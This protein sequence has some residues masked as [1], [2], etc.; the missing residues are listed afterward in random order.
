MDAFD[1]GD[2][3]T[4]TGL[5]GDRGCAIASLLAV[6]LRSFTTAEG[7]DARSAVTG[8]VAG[9][10]LARERPRCPTWDQL[11]GARQWQSAPARQAML[12]GGRC[13]FRVHDLPLQSS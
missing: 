7:R 3:E 4:T 6:T 12:N 10:I 11:H 8:S 13:T 2:L 9:K 1:R 5:L